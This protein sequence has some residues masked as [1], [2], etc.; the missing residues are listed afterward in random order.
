[1]PYRAVHRQDSLVS[2]ESFASSDQFHISELLKSLAILCPHVG[3][4]V[5]RSHGDEQVLIVLGAHAAPV[6]IVF[7][8]RRAYAGFQT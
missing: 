1:M 4:D 2:P 3:G 5:S 7:R 8:I 6:C